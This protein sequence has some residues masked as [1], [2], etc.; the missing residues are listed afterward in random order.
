MRWP[1]IDFGELAGTASAAAPNAARIAIV[2]T[3]SFARVPV[4]WAQM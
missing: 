2:S 1:T 3:R 4:P